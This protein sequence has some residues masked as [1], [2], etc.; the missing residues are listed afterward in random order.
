MVHYISFSSPYTSEMVEAEWD[1]LILWLGSRLRAIVLHLTSQDMQQL[2]LPER[3]C[4]WRSLNTDVCHC[5]MLLGVG[6]VQLGKP[7]TPHP[8]MT[9]L[10]TMMNENL[11]PTR[12]DLD[13]ILSLKCRLF[14]D[15]MFP[16]GWWKAPNLTNITKA[17]E[18]V[19]EWRLGRC[20]VGATS[21]PQRAIAQRGEVIEVDD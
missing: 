2:S 20:F 18:L 5:L 13:D 19:H 12:E 9:L 15:V 14:P 16:V 21:V 17:E 4:Y 10:F 11:R 1:S 7:L 6:T 8:C 3:N